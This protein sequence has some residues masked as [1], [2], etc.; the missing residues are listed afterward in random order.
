MIY[1]W[2]VRKDVILLLFAYEK[3]VSADLTPKQAAQLGK[4]VKQEFQG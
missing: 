4:L 3:S 1:Y 2:A